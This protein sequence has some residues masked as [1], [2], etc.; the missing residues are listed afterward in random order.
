M[1]IPE[2]WRDWRSGESG[3]VYESGCRLKTGEGEDIKEF[4]LLDKI[5]EA[6]LPPF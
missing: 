2:L 4:C 5:H 6:S 1:G 3:H